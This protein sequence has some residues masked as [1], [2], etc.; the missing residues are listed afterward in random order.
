MDLK[1]K[2]GSQFSSRYGPADASL[3][4]TATLPVPTVINIVTHSNNSLESGR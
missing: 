3:L 4:V 2:M 1:S